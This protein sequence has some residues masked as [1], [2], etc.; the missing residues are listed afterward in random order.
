MI[1]GWETTVASSRVALSAAL[2]LLRWK[3]PRFGKLSINRV[4][5]LDE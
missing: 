3:G 2:L 4:Q 5:P 1:T